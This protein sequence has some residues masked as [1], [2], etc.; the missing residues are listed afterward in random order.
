MLHTK[1]Q[2]FREE[3]WYKQA[4][5]AM[6]EQLYSTLWTPRDCKIEFLKNLEGILTE[7]TNV[8]KI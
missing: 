4:Q 3:K 6:V 2:T 7:F 8:G 5:T 1:M